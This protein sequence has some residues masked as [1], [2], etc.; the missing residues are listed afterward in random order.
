MPFGQQLIGNIFVKL[1]LITLN[2]YY[3]PNLFIFLFK[4]Q[5][6]STFVRNRVNG[7]VFG[8]GLNNY[9]QLGLAKKN[10]ETVFAPQLTTFENVKMITGG[11]HHTLVLTNDNK[12]FA[13]GRKEYG[14]LGLGDI[15]EDVEKLT[16]IKTLDSFNVT[17]LEC[18]ECCSFAVTDD[19]KAYSWGM[20]SNQQLGVGSDEDQFEPVLLTGAQVREKHVIRVSSGGQHTLFIAAESIIQTNG[21]HK[22]SIKCNG[23]KDNDEPKI[24][25]G[26]K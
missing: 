17:Q 16:P 2:E 11:Q 6:F 23:N 24:I 9:N 21:I 8:F 4:F 25:N 3:I 10:T 5:S 14:R 18:G 20:G 22:E 15:E 19:G 1:L 12:C 13:I 26:S 7:V